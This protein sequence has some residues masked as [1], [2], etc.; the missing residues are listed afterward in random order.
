MGPLG[1]GS[2]DPHVPDILPQKLDP[3]KGEPCP[4]SVPFL[5]ALWST[6]SQLGR[7]GDLVMVLHTDAP[8]PMTGH[9][10]PIMA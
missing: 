7:F 3:R 1:A 9:L 8:A 5:P 6:E 2:Q 10:G 4:N